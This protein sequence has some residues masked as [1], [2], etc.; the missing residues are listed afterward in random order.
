M[1]PLLSERGLTG[2]RGWFLLVVG[3]DA[4]IQVLI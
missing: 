4:V 1:N 3:S 2:D